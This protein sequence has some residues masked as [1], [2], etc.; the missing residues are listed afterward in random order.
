MFPLS[1]TAMLAGVLAITALA[2]CQFFTH[3]FVLD[4]HDLLD[5]V[6]P[7]M[8][9]PVDAFNTGNAFQSYYRPVFLTSLWVDNMLFGAQG[10][11]YHAMNVILHL[12]AAWCAFLFAERLF[13]RPLPAAAAALLFAIQPVHTENVSWISGRTDI[14]C[15]IF[16]FLALSAFYDLLER[17]KLKDAWLAAL[18][19]LLALGSKETA[20]VTPAL[21]LILVMVWSAL[22]KSAPAI[23][24][25]ETQKRR[26]R[27]PQVLVRRQSVKP[28]VLGLVL[29][30]SC[31]GAM[32]LLR[33]LV[34]KSDF[35]E[36]TFTTAGAQWLNA[37]RCLGM[38]LQHSVIGGGYEYLIL[39]WRIQ[40]PSF[41]LAL[42]T[43]TVDWVLIAV[44]IAS[45]L[46][47]LVATIVWKRS[48]TAIGLLGFMLF[49]VP[50]LGFVPIQ[51]IFSV[52]FLYIPSFFLT[53]AFVDGVLALLAIKAISR[54]PRA[55]VILSAG[56]A[57]IILLWGYGTFTQDTLW[58]NDKTLFLS[59][60]NEAA[61]SPVYRFSIANAY[62][63]LGE[64][65]SA[66]GEFSQAIEI[67]PRYRDA[68]INLGG[69]YMMMG[70]R[71]EDEYKEAIT[72]YEGALKIFPSDPR[73]YMLI[74]DAYLRTGDRDHA[75]LDYSMAYSLDKTSL[76]VRKRLDMIHVEIPGMNN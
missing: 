68:Y 17:R 16:V 37:V 9:S 46:G 21:C 42:P 65:R 10:W 30:A 52:R 28:V 20:I 39:G 72:T 1:R 64:Y 24:D 50:A 61:E 67:Y 6:I 11:G 74:G 19:F 7:A 32:L 53:L 15:A 5:R 36:N 59:M 62:R 25:A 34:M 23:P 57:V 54:V 66:A 29:F 47:A 49:L 8:H 45:Y 40:D 33:S 76:E 18:Y 31:A 51:S 58:Q 13:R 63:Y 2:Y 60:K 44:P 12:L 26:H 41:N 70:Q 71:N 48:V 55:T 73:F 56:Y 43:E 27:K 22:P 75:R 4:D 69:C 35:T 3:G 38:Y 14:L